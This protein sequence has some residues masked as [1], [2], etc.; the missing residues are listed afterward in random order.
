MPIITDIINAP[1][2]TGTIVML[3]TIKRSMIMA[4]NIM[5]NVLLIMAMKV[6]ITILTVMITR[7]KLRMTM[8]MAAMNMDTIMGNA[9]MITDTTEV[10]N[11]DTNT[12]KVTTIQTSMVMDMIIRRRKEV[13]AMIMSTKPRMS[14]LPGRRGLSRRGI[15]I[16]WQLRLVVHGIRRHLLVQR[17]TRWRNRPIS[18]SLSIVL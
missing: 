4:I 1:K 2:I 15:P 14:Y 7:K 6:T 17:T 3:I 13:I 12:P 5:R 9:R 18:F 10:M 8:D 16:Q 11:T